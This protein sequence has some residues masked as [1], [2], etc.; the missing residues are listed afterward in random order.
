MIYDIY[1]S[2]QISP[3]S[4]G[5][6]FFLPSFSFLSAF[7]KFEISV[8]CPNP[9][10]FWALVLSRMNLLLGLRSIIEFSLDKKE[11]KVAHRRQKVLAGTGSER[12]KRGF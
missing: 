6:A 4:R 1:V 11:K 12:R 8:L 5:E 10:S 3:C 9:L 7:L 2:F